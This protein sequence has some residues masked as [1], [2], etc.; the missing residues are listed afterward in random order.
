MRR[1]HREGEVLQNSRHNTRRRG[2]GRDWGS[3][4]ICPMG[5]SNTWQNPNS[6][7]AP[8]GGQNPNN[9]PNFN[10]N[11]RVGPD[12]NWSPSAGS[13]PKQNKAGSNKN[14]ILILA[15]ILTGILMLT[16]IPI[17]ILTPSRIV[18]GIPTLA[19]TLIRILMLDGNQG[20]RKS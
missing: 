16:R 10:Q 2:C 1:E 7:Q 9:G 20:K 11:L 4:A 14:R 5:S 18:A 8:S 19:R 13:N 15:R 3:T 17:G 6:G 12:P